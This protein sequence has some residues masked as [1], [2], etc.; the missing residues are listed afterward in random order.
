MF[1]F[2]NFLLQGMSV[3]SNSRKVLI[4]MLLL[5]GQTPFFTVQHC[6]S[7]RISH[8]FIS[9][10][11]LFACF[12]CLFSLRLCS[13]F[14]QLLLS[15]CYLLIIP[16]YFSL[17]WFFAVIWQRVWEWKSRCVQPRLDIV[18]GW[19]NTIP[20]CPSISS[21]INKSLK[22]LSFNLSQ[23]SH[24]ESCHPLAETFTSKLNWFNLISTGKCYDI[25]RIINTSVLKNEAWLPH[26]WFCAFLCFE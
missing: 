19:W 17:Y 23:E 26:I 8:F 3:K 10:L 6:R 11:C 4:Y 21:R 16:F 7:A 9:V 18:T 2:S 1:W 14:A 20:A 5:F 22:V 25:Q 24:W 12:C 15:K 13:I